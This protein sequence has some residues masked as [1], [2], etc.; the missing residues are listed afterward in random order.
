MPSNEW[1][2]FHYKET[3]KG[4]IRKKRFYLIRRLYW[5]LRFKY[6]WWREEDENETI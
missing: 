2:A 3:K 1:Y 5:R 6:D 4:K